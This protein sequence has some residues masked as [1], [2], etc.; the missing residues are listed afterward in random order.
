[1]IHYRY[2]SGCVS[3][4]LVEFRQFQKGACLQC[5]M[6]IRERNY[7]FSSV[8]IN[9]KVMSCRS[10]NYQFAVYNINIDTNKI[11]NLNIKIFTT[12]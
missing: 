1:M 5:V 2:K 4:T 7:Y 10:Q 12:Q 6:R 8:I 11:F 3:D 9:F